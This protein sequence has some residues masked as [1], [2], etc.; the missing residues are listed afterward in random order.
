MLADTRLNACV[1]GP[2]LGRGPYARD[3]ALA[4]LRA[5]R[6]LVLDADG[7]TS[8]SDSPAALFGA[9][10]AAALAGSSRVVFTP[11][12]GEFSK[13]F[14]QINENS[15]VRSKLEKARIAAERSAAVI[16][17]K[18]ADTVVAAPDGRASIASNAPPWLATAGSGDV[19]AGLIGG[20]LAQGLPA[21]DAANLGVWLHGEAGRHAGPGLI[22]EDLPDIM[23]AVLRALY[24]SLGVHLER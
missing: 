1:I 5:N 4:V 12:T 17:L 11:H 9:V 7:L 20:L 13:L 14:S 15:E 16:V 22:A 2:G 18:G 24:A 10:A 3:L 21:F 8:F 6:A 23:P 19:L